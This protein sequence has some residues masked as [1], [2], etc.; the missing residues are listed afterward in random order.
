M[1]KGHKKRD[2]KK[3]KAAAIFMIL[4]LAMALFFTLQEPEQS[5][6]LSEAVR[7]WLEKIGIDVEYNS[8]RANIH[9]LEYFIVG[10]A[11]TCFSVSMRQKIWIGAAI[12]CGIG[13]ADE[14]I[15]VLLPGLE[16]SSG[17]LIRDCVGVA[18]VAVIIGLVSYLGP[19]GG[20][21]VEME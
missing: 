3:E 5:R 6:E 13:I 4:A 21:V 19:Q 11:V 17:D 18:V 20:L 14:G 1:C 16:F 7:M 9:F 15:N 2:V 12:G 10:L 8:L